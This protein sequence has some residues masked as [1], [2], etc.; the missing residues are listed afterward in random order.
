M[1]YFYKAQF[2][3]S[4]IQR[5]FSKNWFSENL[6]TLGNMLKSG[7]GI[8][9]L[10]S[11]LA[12]IINFI[13][14]A[15][16]GRM[17]SFD[18]LGVISIVTTFAY[19]LN[20]FTGALSTT[21]T[22]SV[23]YLEG[24][25]T[26]MGAT[27][28]RKKWGGVFAVGILGSLIWIEAI[29][30]ISAFFQV[31]NT[32]VL[33]FT[34]AILFGTLDFFNKGYLSGTFSFGLV[35]IVI[36]LEVIT[37]LGI[38]IALVQNNMHEYAVV[39]IPASIACVWIFSSIAA[40]S[41]YRKAPKIKPEKHEKFPFGFYS[42]SLINGF[43][44]AI[45]LSLDVIFA[46]HYLAPDDAGRY[47]MLSLIGKMVYFFGSLLAVFIVTIISR[48]EGKHKN[49]EKEFLKIFA[50][51][52]A[53]TLFA[54]LL[55]IFTK[56]WIVPFLLGPRAVVIIPYI[57]P[58]TLSMMFFSLTF[59]VALY[60][61]AR[62]HY[63]FSVISFCT[64]ILM[65]LSIMRSHSTIENFV[66][67]VFTTNVVFFV[68]IMVTHIFYK[69][70]VSLGKDIRDTI[71]VVQKLPE[72]RIPSAGHKRILIFNWRDVD[73]VSAGGAEIYIQT[74]ASHW[75]ADG[76]AVTLFCGNDG[77]QK[78]TAYTNGV[79][80]IRR[81]GFPGLYVV[82]AIYYIFKFRGKFDVIID[83]ENGIPFFMP[84]FAKEPVY[85][86]VHHI[87]QDVFKKSL[88]RPLAALACFMEKRFMPFVYR[89]STF[90]TVSESSKAEMQEYK[91]SD[92][93]I[94][95][96]Y[97]GVDLLR[98]SPGTKSPT[99]L[100][101]YVGRL[102]NY[103]SLPIALQAFAKVIALRPDARFIIAG[104][105]D[106]RPS[107][108]SLTKKLGLESHVSFLGK[109]TEEEK[110]DIL[111]KSWVFVNPSFKEGWGITT[112][113]ANACGTPVV[114]SDVA[115]LRDSVQDG[116]TGILVPHGN[117]EMFAK[118]IDQLLRDNIVRHN[119]SQ[120]A[121]AWAANFEWKK[122]SDHFASLFLKS[123]HVP[124]LKSAIHTTLDAP[125]RSAWQTLWERA[126]FA[127]AYNSPSWFE[128]AIE[129]FGHTTI[130][131][132]SIVDTSDDTLVALVP[133][134][135]TRIS[136]V[137]AYIPAGLD[138]VDRTPILAD[139]TNEKIAKEVMRQ[140][141]TL[142]TV[143]M[144][145]LT[146]SE[147]SMLM[148]KNGVSVFPI[149][150]ESVVDFTKGP[151]GEFSQKNA[152]RLLRKADQN[153]GGPVE[154]IDSADASK[155]L[156]LC[157]EIDTKS[158]KNE[159]GKGTFYKSDT[160]KFY[161]L[162][163]KKTPQSMGISIIT[164][165]GEPAAFSIQFNHQNISSGSQKAYLAKYKKHGPGYLTMIKLFDT[166]RE[167]GQVAYS[168][169]KGIDDFKLIFT[170]D[171]HQKYACVLSRSLFARVWITQLLRLKEYFYEVTS[172]YP[173][174]YIKY[175][176]LKNFLTVSTRN[177]KKSQD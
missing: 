112:I 164:I 42:A 172:K 12:N 138:F 17:L 81:G 8:L 79:R 46:K 39:A 155:N 111:R 2:Y 78:P 103:K 68:I 40:L 101:S 136:G 158:V 59:S 130:R 116:T 48:S 100:I 43:S 153:A 14:N 34:I 122:S 76:H 169:G 157:F 149:Y 176:K 104:D 117:V 173:G 109:V 87:H 53:L 83:C 125:L 11:L 80:I 36:L 77:T 148:K 113:E 33:V 13:F 7:G 54:G 28:Y 177:N 127:N 166:I 98:F 95:V 30:T 115:G 65:S 120:Q 119:Y 31:S 47:A 74:I 18:D 21:V 150:V 91:I 50:G 143:Y 156:T 124:M 151:Y 38:L 99:P 37:K 26:G 73:H 41:V 19:L 23:S 140:L 174:M 105:G 82:A 64:A 159:K 92:K 144:N 106:A 49:P 27:F 29:P 60:H 44:F 171:V 90:I 114:A 71:S 167:R 69:F 108:E 85:C 89:R 10:S 35:A 123:Q 152:A 133:L 121:V 129:A 93:E 146:E 20:I 6:R 22:H 9:I 66:T 67:I 128:A 142:G 118:H 72:A 1:S 110:M 131:I 94:A 161:T 137:S 175:K 96:V 45:F 84:L 56:S 107:L 145:G 102:K 16:A 168:F 132:I 165:A 52:I 5:T 61:L 141:R 58:Y 55:I 134:I 154:I 51:T 63:L 3:H 170:K 163:A 147:S 15:Y 86:L 75:V 57:V 97:N 162:L 32:I 135:K 88:P 25:N 160:R 4:I 70:F 139:L 126:P 62:K 24:Q